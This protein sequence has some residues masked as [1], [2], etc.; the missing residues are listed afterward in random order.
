MIHCD[1]CSMVNSLLLHSQ[2]NTSKVHLTL[3]RLNNL[4]LKLK[5]ERPLFFLS[6]SQGLEVFFSFESEMERWR[7]M[8][9]NMLLLQLRYSQ[10]NQCLSFCLPRELVCFTFT[11]SFLSRHHCCWFSLYKDMPFTLIKPVHPSDAL[12]ICL[13]LCSFF[14]AMPR[15]YP[16]GDLM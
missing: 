15:W 10:R 16:T 3:H 1:R 8:I 5:G 7:R 2:K 6:L 14:L 12:F 11:V 4:W 9:Y 13:M